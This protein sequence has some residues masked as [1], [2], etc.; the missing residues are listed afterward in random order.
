MRLTLVCLG[1]LFMVSGPVCAR[2]T[3]APL[4]GSVSLGR[5][6]SQPA[7][8]SYKSSFSILCSNTGSAHD[9]KV[10]VVNFGG[11]V[12]KVKNI[13]SGTSIP[14]SVVFDDR[15]Q[16]SELPICLSVSLGPGKN[17]VFDLPIMIR[18]SLKGQSHGIYEA[19]IPLKVVALENYEFENE[20]CLSYK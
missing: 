16:T 11:A 3:C 18:M 2:I 17:K 12:K 9:K 7:F 19:N 6:N 4:S 5:I 8:K 15:M 10:M 14:I 20:R 13:L 1:L